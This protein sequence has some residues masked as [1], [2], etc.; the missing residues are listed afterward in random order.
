MYNT[1]LH[2]NRNK[3]TKNIK[4]NQ[5]HHRSKSKLNKNSTDLNLGGHLRSQIERLFE[6]K[7]KNIRKRQKKR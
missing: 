3:K 5:N 2:N 1:D 6:N 7:N 4:E